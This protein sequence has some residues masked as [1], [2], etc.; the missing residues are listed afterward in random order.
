MYN[1][2]SLLGRGLW[3]CFFQ[4]DVERRPNS[5][6]RSNARNVLLMT[7]VRTEGNRER[8]KRNEVCKSV[9]IFTN[10][11]KSEGKDQTD[12][13]IFWQKTGKESSMRLSS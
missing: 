4:C 3:R 12:R 5:T 7:G 6:D 9:E 1:L 8:P 13:H 2:P 11:E 10:Q